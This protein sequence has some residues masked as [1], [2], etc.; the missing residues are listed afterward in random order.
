VSML[1]AVALALRALIL[2]RPA[3]EGPAMTAGPDSGWVRPW[4]QSRPAVLGAAIVPP[5]ALVALVQ[6]AK[7]GYLLAYL[8]AAVIA[9]LLVP[10]ALVRAG[11]GTA[12]VP[13]GWT[14]LATLGVVTVAA[15]GAQRFLSGNGVLPEHE[16]ASTGLW[17]RQPRY[18]APYPD[19][20]PA[21]RSADA[22]DVALRALGPQVRPDR[23]VIVFDTPDGGAN[24]YRNAG[25]ELPDDRIALIAPGQVLYNE[26]QGALYYA[27]GRNVAVG[28]SGS[29]F[30]VAS[31]A[32]PGLAQLVTEGYALPVPTPHLIGGYR[33]WSVLP[34][35]SLLGVGFTVQAGHRPLGRGI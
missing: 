11:P 23:D 26:Q 4:Y 6:F 31:P 34:G 21:I 27:P 7:G 3:E 19:T 35:V 9:L 24:I 13:A 2:H 32:L 16:L 12:R 30:V 25:W 20:R 18:Q 33:V 1:A 15:L 28:P 14:V 29:V 5:M 10:G 8:P 22:I 17:I